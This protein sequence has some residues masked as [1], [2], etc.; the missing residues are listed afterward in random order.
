[1]TTQETTEKGAG[2]KIDV[3]PEQTTAVERS[4]E[5]RGR[6]W[7]PFELVD[8]MQDEMARLW[9]Q[10]WPLMPRPLMRPLRRM[11][12][13]PTMWM[14]TVDVYEQDD[15]V[16]VKAEL[17]G[18]KKEDIEVTVDQG[19]LVIHGERTAES[20]VKEE[21]YY[22]AERSYGS[23]YRRIPLPPDVKTE[24]ITATY[25]DGLLEIRVPKSAREQPLPRRVPLT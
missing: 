17:P 5:R 25:K 15:T 9:G 19:D 2:T 20:E 13:G 18:L 1:M 22:R 8:E 24:Q 3:K 21:H 10:A 4:G 23:F 11:G 14:P 16:V 6:R 7:D 12:A